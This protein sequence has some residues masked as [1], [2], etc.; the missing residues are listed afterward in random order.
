MSYASMILGV[1]LV[2]LGIKMKITRLVFIKMLL[3]ISGSALVLFGFITEL[4]S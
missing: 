3:I 1:A 4:A 2:L